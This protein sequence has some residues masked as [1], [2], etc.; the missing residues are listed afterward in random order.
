RHITNLEKL[1]DH[2]GAQRV[3]PV[4]HDWGGPIGTGWA[5]RHPAR[6]AGAVILNTFAFVREPALKL[7]WF[8]KFLVLGKG[9]W[10]R[11]TQK[12]FFVEF[13]MAKGGPRRYTDDELNPYRAPFP[14][15]E[16]RVGIAR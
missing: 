10:R 15:P 7:P 14:T 9:G 3:V 5:V 13:L 4:M 12:N 6:V 1:L 8:F 16:T 2:A 11:I